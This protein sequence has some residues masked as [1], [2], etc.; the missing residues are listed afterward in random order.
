M[1]FDKLTIKAQEAFQEAQSL[2]ETYQQTSVDVEHLLLALLRQQGGVAGPLLQKI[3]VEP[4]IVATKV[5]AELD[6]APKVQNAPGYGAS[7]TGR[8]QTTLAQAFNEASK[9]DDEYVSSEHMLLAIADDNGAAGRELKAAGVTKANLLKAITELRQGRKVTDP[10]AE[11]N[12]QALEKYGVDLTERA[13]NGKLDPVI[14]RDEEIRRVIQVLSR[15]TKNNPVLIG[16]PGVGKTAVVEGLAQRIISGDVPEGLKGK[17]V[18]SLDLGAL[19]AGQSSEASS[20]SASKPF[21][22]TSRRPRARSFSSSTSFT[23][24]SERG[25]LRARWTRPTCSSRCWLAANFDAW[26]RRR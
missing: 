25:K 9:L 10:N 20:K 5:E 11:T 4:G 21:S 24:W 17:R 8:L 2:A 3:G 16:E 15:R 1:R 23:H 12:Y 7:L 22:K 14:G 6:R 19:V 18:V 13:Q 26:A